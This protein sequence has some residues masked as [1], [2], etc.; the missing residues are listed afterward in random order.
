MPGVFR[1]SGAPRVSTYKPKSLNYFLALPK[2][3]ADVKAAAMGKLNQ[4][5]V[6]AEGLLPQDTEVI[7]KASKIIDEGKNAMI[8]NFINGKDVNLEDV[9]RLKALGQQ[10]DG[11]QKHLELA[12]AN[13][14]KMS[15]MEDQ[16]KMYALKSDNPDY[17]L[18]AID[19]MKKNYKGA[20]NS[21]GSY[22]PVTL[23]DMPKYIDLYT[24]GAALLN[25]AASNMNVYE[26]AREAGVKPEIVKV[27]DEQG[28]EV[29]QMVIPGI[30]KVKTNQA[31]LL[32][33]VNGF[34][35]RLQDKEVKDYLKFSNNPAY[36]ESV[37]TR[38]NSLQDV[39]YHRT[40]VPGAPT[41]KNVPKSSITGP[42]GVQ[43]DSDY[44]ALGGQKTDVTSVVPTKGLEFVPTQNF[45]Q[46]QGDYDQ[47]QNNSA[48]K[49]VDEVD[50]VNPYTAS[51]KYQSKSLFDATQRPENATY[52]VDENKYNEYYS[53]LSNTLIN[54]PEIKIEDVEEILKGSR[55]AYAN[56]KIARAVESNTRLRRK[57]REDLE[58][59]KAY[60]KRAK[61]NTS[62]I[63]PRFDAAIKDKQSILP[64]P[65]AEDNI[66]E[67]LTD[68]YNSD[69]TETF[70]M[71]T[72]YPVLFEGKNASSK[73]RAF[74]RRVGQDLLS[75]NVTLFKLNSDNNENELVS[76]SALDEFGKE[77]G[78]PTGADLNLKLGNYLSENKTPNNV[79][80]GAPRI[81]GPT[82]KYTDYLPEDVKRGLTPEKAKR[83]NELH[84]GDIAFTVEM[85]KKNGSGTETYTM[86][87]PNTID[88]LKPPFADVV[89]PT[90]NAGEVE[91][92]YSAMH[93]VPANKFKDIRI[94]EDLP[95]EYNKFFTDN[96]LEVPRSSR[97]LQVKKNEDGARYTLRT[98]Y[99]SIIQQFNPTKKIA[100]TGNNKTEYYEAVVDRDN[101]FNF[102]ANTL[103]S[104]IKAYEEAW[105][106]KYTPKNQ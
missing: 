85:P 93:N 74:K 39:L 71:N 94:G 78:L 103:P 32:K 30:D 104:I 35:Q 49:P 86:L 19:L 95:A 90:G 43:I 54:K 51:A 16:L 4:L 34:N 68:I 5:G 55:G 57:L 17:F 22:N 27:Q 62:V 56:T 53:T 76:V 28:N 88:E 75:N 70:N 9:K 26:K 40:V 24:E 21:D 92:L 65:P 101:F 63:K 42:N 50:A 106:A 8:D 82:Y 10:Q 13:V 14:A 79:V 18:S 37:R 2:L 36:L 80:I 58:D 73:E 52:T 12:K 91:T 77:A 44:G 61:V 29:L 87:I 98:K 67:R 97:L 60:T 38:L 6:D 69:K 96:K 47:E 89:I 59:Y 11:I 25:A 100:G 83:L 20:L 15:Q 1:Y 72:Y 99:K 31:A 3:K 23:P 81:M 48:Q 102:T 33:A 105:V 41:Y 7:S 84:A 46:V 64:R 45:V 66:L